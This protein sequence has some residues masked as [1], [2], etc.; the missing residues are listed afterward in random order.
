M[1]TSRGYVFDGLIHSPT[2][3]NSLTKANILIDQAGRA[4]LADFGLLTIISD[5]ANLSSS[6]SYTHGGTA[7]WMSPERIS[8]EGFGFK[9]SRPTQSSDCY[10]LGMVIYETISENPPFHKHTDVAVLVKVLRGEHPPRGVG[11]TESL[12][13]TL[14]MCW[15]HQPNIRPSIKE[16]LRCLEMASNSSK[17]PSLDDLNTSL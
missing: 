5:P 15:A 16:V 12:W 6:S 7:R 8:P 1:V 2:L 11:F 4:R 17:L 14:K 3:P 13:T 9:D 10:S